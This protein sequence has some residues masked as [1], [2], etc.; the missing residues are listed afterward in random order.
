MEVVQRNEQPRKMLLWVRISW[1]NSV[2]ACS[3]CASLCMCECLL[4]CVLTLCRISAC[5]HESMKA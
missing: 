1:V 5:A 4:P 3:L 2:L